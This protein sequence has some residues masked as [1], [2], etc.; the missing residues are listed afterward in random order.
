M[1]RTQ[2]L[3]LNECRRI[4][5]YASGLVAHGLMIGADDDRN[6]IART[7][8]CCRQDMRKHGAACDLV[9]HLGQA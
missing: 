9:Q 5:G 4:E 2:A 1:R 7:T 8:R 3:A 6:L